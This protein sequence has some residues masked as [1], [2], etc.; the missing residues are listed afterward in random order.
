MHTADHSFN[1]GDVDGD[2]T[3]AGGSADK[4]ARLNLAK[5]PGLELLGVKE[6]ELCESV[7]LLPT[8]FLAAKEA[9]V[10]EAYRN[11]MLTEEGI[12]RV[13]KV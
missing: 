4:R 11:G 8:H 1:T 7:P 3:A 2:G 13:I 10:R 12:R 6:R 5:A 9:I